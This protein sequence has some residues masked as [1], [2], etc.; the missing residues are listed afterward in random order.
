M[1]TFKGFYVEVLGCPKNIS[2]SEFI[3]REMEKAGLEFKKDPEEADL[4]VVN[5][6]AF[7]ISAVA[8]SVDTINKYIEMGKK[9]IVT[10]CLPMR[11]DRNL[12]RH[13]NII[14]VL[15]IPEFSRFSDF[16]EGKIVK[17][18]ERFI[19]GFNPSEVYHFT[20]P[21]YRYI[22][23][24]DGCNHRC[25]FCTIPHI[26]GRYRSKPMGIILKEVQTLPEHVKEIIL[27]AQDTSKYG[28]DIYGRQMLHVLLQKLSGVFNGWIRVM[29]LYPTT[30]YPELLKVLKEEENIVKYIDIPFQHVST[31]VLKS[32]KRGYGKED[33]ERIVEQIRDAGNFFIRSTFIVGSPDETDKDFNELIEFLNTY[34]IE[35]IGLFPYYHEEGTALY[36]KK[37]LPDKIKEKRLVEL[38]KLSGKISREKNQE[39]IGKSVK[40]LIDGEEEGEFYGRTQYDA[41]EIDNIVWIRGECNEGDFEE[42][43]IVDSLDYELIGDRVQKTGSQG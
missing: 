26:K 42:A 31:K 40:V 34:R 39:F 28:V 21:H 37:D 9:I 13:R 1:K 5:T 27:V 35:R 4:I 22:K 23:I 20:P 36:S 15:R 41:P 32:M 29:Y 38:M 14:G 30:F 7:I 2:D 24:A 12:I 17:S 19:I 18:R 11:V 3:V 16:L 6:C 33:V 43:Y 25:A 8:A 10:G